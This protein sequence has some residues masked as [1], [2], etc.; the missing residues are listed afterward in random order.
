MK[1]ILIALALVLSLQVADAQVKPTAVIKKAVENAEAAAQD[2]KK[3]IKPAT[4]LKLAEAYVNA[5]TTYTHEEDDDVLKKKCE[6]LYGIKFN[7][8]DK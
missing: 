7:K 6:V 8:G 5:Y 3:N 1:R 4:W 2:P